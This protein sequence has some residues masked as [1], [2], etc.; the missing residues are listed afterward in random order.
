MGC[1]HKRNRFLCS[2]VL[3]LVLLPAV[4][5]AS[6]QGNIYDYALEPARDVLVSINTTPQQSI[7]AKSATYRFSLEPGSYTITAT[8][9]DNSFSATEDIVIIKDGSY[10]RDII[11]FPVTDERIVD[12]EAFT[13]AAFLQDQNNNLTTIIIILVISIIAIFILLGAAFFIVIYKEKR[14]LEQHQDELKEYINHL[15]EEREER[16][17]EIQASRTEPEKPLVQPQTI[18][19]ITPEEASTT[20]P[21]QTPLQT[22][23]VDAAVPAEAVVEKEKPA[24]DDD[25]TLIKQF[26]RS[27]SPTT[28]KDV[29]QAFPLISEAKI[30]LIISELEH[31]GKVR[32][33]KKGRGNIVTR[34]EVHD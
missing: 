34:R 29:R 26:I 17:K 12:D 22:Y 20:V 2:A 24:R 30:S 15:R 8:T 23:S 13:P 1:G 6:I 10:S 16:L 4:H 33:F 28:Q 25:R 18:V 11:L 32:K 5:A 14:R 19:R 21:L 27:H 31:D 9:N 7:L 3:L